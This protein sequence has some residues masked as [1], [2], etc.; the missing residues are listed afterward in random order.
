MRVVACAAGGFGD[1]CGSPNVSMGV[2]ISGGGFD[3]DGSAG[4]HDQGRAASGVW[5]P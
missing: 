1:V 5:N 2:V 4:E 3:L